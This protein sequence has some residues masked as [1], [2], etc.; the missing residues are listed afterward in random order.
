VELDALPSVKPVQ[1]SSAAAVHIEPLAQRSLVAPGPKDDTH[2][3]C[4]L[5]FFPLHPECSMTHCA[6]VA[7]R[8]SVAAVHFDLHAATSDDAHGPLGG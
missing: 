8:P 1:A 5:H 6:H 3:F 4:G 7:V 2:P